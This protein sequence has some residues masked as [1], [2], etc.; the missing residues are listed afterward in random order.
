MNNKVIAA[1]NGL[2]SCTEDKTCASCRFCMAHNTPEGRRALCENIAE[3]VVLMPFY[4]HALAQAMQKLFPDRVVY[5]DE[6]DICSLLFEAVLFEDDHTGITPLSYF[7]DNAPLSAD[8]KRLYEAWR[9]HTRYEFFAVEKVTPGKELHLTDLAAKNRYRVY[10]DRGT[11]TIKEGT[12]II[13]RIVPFLKGWMITTEMV[14]S[15]SGRAV[16]EQ[17]QKSYGMPVSQ[18][19]FVQKYH[20]DGKRRRAASVAGTA[21]GRASCGTGATVEE[22]PTLTAK[23]LK[24]AAAIDSKVH[25]LLK[26]GCD[27]AA[28]FMEMSGDMAQFKELMDTVTQAAMDELCR[29]FEWFYCYADI[30]ERVAAGIASGEIKVPK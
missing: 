5:D 8:E 16:R 6:K 4:Q 10:E 9:A 13:A 29:R 30:L 3:F 11:A 21:G 28:I 25:G 26:A 27:D 19:T 24:T 17:L 18:F 14:V 12:V 7:V 15:F 1:D 2:C 23:Q 22:Q 20:D